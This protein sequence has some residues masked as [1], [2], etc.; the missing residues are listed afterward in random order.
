MTW[1]P[2]LDSE[3]NPGKPPK[4][5]LFYRLRDNLV[6][7]MAREAG[8]PAPAPPIKLLI[9]SGTSWS[10]PDDVAVANATLVGGGGEANSSN[11]GSATTLTYN[12][13]TTTAPGGNANGT[14]GSVA[15]NADWYIVGAAARGG[16]GGMTPLGFGDPG[17]ESSVAAEYNAGGFGAGGGHVSD[18]GGSGT[19]AHV[20]LIREPGLDTVAFVIG[21]GGSGGGS[22][23]GN[24]SPGCILLEY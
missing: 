5:S 11:N 21:A 19:V 24:G 1:Q 15:T 9:T 14:A 3:I 22:G 16:R 12:S 8:A 23:A 18:G 10:W 7:A 6:A 20:R 17:L 13:V 4:S 2:I